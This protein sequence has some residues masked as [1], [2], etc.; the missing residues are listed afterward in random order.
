MKPFSKILNNDYWT[1]VT[2]HM[3][4]FIIRQHSLELDNTLNI[5]FSMSSVH[6]FYIEKIWNLHS[7][8][9]WVPPILVYNFFVHIRERGNHKRDEH[10]TVT[11]FSQIMISAISEKGLVTQYNHH[12][13]LWTSSC[14]EN[15]YCQYKWHNVSTHK[16][17]FNWQPK[18]PR[19]ILKRLLENLQTLHI[20]CHCW[21]VDLAVI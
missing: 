11:F 1:M 2:I 8:I 12:T 6:L 7:D 16:A 17:T 9:S 20:S 10:L 13:V 14:H 21:A 4:N 15:N 3:A 19:Y 18:T 5:T